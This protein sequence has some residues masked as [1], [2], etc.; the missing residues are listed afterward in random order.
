V[1]LTKQCVE[2]KESHASLC[3]LS[4]SAVHKIRHIRASSCITNHRVTTKMINF[5]AKKQLFGS[6]CEVRYHFNT[7]LLPQEKSF[8][9][10]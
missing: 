3:N 1:Y 10:R 4:S 8:G 2:E 5:N 9:W 6:L 7:L